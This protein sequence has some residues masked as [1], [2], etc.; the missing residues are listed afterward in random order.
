M[1][2]ENTGVKDGQDF[3]E[4]ARG[5][6]PD[7]LDLSCAKIDGFDLLDHHEPRQVR[8]IYNGHMERKVTVSLGDWANNG[9]AGAF[10][11]QGVADNKGR[12]ATFL[13]M[14]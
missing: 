3:F 6:L 10:V 5:R 1:R 11:E 8:I 7:Q 2:S 13:F 12:S 9:K 4:H 14:P